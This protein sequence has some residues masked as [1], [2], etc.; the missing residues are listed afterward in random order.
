LLL[1]GENADDEWAK[2]QRPHSKGL[3]T[4]PKEGRTTLGCNVSFP[5]WMSNREMPIVSVPTLLCF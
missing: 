4:M 2:Q 5:W 1:F 3:V